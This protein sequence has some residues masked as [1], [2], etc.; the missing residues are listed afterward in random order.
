VAHQGRSLVQGAS[1]GEDIDAVTAAVLTASRLLVAVSARSLA[2]VEETLTLPQFR[3][4]VVLR[5]RGTMKLVALADRLAVN[6]STA[7]RMADRLGAAGMITRSVSPHSRREVAI[8]LT[9]AGRRTVDEVTARRRA[10]IAVIVASME[11]ASRLALVDALSAFSRAGGEPAV[12]A[13]REAYPLD[14]DL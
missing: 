11:P 5:G 2:A 9:E 14:W 6:P 8:A 12:E 10:E 1:S 13:A 7:L 3:F 4:L